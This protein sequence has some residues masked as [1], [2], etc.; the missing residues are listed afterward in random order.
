MAWDMIQ[1]FWDKQSGTGKRKD[2]YHDSPETNVPKHCTSMNTHSI[3]HQSFCPQRLPFEHHRNIL[4]CFWVL[5][6]Q[7]LYVQSKVVLGRLSRE[8]HRV[9]ALKE[10]QFPL[11]SPSTGGYWQSYSSL[12]CGLWSYMNDCSRVLNCL[13][14]LFFGLLNTTKHTQRRAWYW[15]MQKLPPF[16]LIF[17]LL[18]N[19]I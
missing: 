13:N 6:T 10:S 5:E 9:E 12:Q 3:T 2:N 7:L 4:D 18:F 16:S 17:A 8:N 11:S 15:S 19:F 14:L 1:Y